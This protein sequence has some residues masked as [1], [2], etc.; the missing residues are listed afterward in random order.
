MCIRDRA[1]AEAAILADKAVSISD[2]ET[3]LNEYDFIFNTIPAPVLLKEHLVK[4][5]KHVTIIDIAS[6]PG[7]VDFAAAARL[8]LSA[9]LCPG[10]PGKY[11]PVSSAQAIAAVSYTHLDHPWISGTAREPLNFLHRLLRHII[12][13]I[14]I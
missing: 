5:K 8:N 2:F 11:A 14:K 4:M 10:L 12:R 6:A 3:H 1:M 7:G 9:F 13:N